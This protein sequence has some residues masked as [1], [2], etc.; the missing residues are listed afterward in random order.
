MPHVAKT[1]LAERTLELVLGQLSET[2]LV[3]LVPTPEKDALLLGT[4]HIVLLTDRTLLPQRIRHVFVFTEL[5]LMNA[6]LTLKTVLEVFTAALLADSTHVAVKV[7]LLN[8]YTK[9]Y[10]K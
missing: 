3:H 2:A 6:R 1:F 10:Q 5:G 7:L 4:K 9:G 8:P